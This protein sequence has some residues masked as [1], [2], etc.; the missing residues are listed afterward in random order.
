M[1]GTGNLSRVRAF[2]PTQAAEDQL[3][4]RFELTRVPL[5]DALARL[6]KAGAAPP[7][8]FPARLG[9]RAVRVVE[10]L[11]ADAI[12]QPIDDSRRWAIAPIESITVIDADLDA[13]PHN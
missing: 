10:L 1:S 8:H 4:S 11:D 13:R 5:R 7:A 2:R 6:T 3:A 9:P 12:I